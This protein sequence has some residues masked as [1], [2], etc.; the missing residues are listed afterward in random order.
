M[1]SLNK[2]QAL[3]PKCCEADAIDLSK[4]TENEKELLS[5]FLQD[6]QSVIV[7]AHHVKHSLEWSWFP[8]EASRE[9]S[10][11]PA[12]LHLQAEAQKVMY[13]LDKMGYQSTLIPYPGK[14]GIRFKN[15]A[16]KTGL[17]KIGDNFLFLHNEWGPWTH[18]RVIL[19]NA[20][21][22]D[23]LKSCEEVCIHC[24]AC[25]TAC[26]AN[27]IKEKEL[28]GTTCGAYQH[29]VAQTIPAYEY[30]CEVCLRICPIGASP[31]SVSIT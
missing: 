19:T 28:L 27:A 26:P 12:D 8:F 13:Y 18:L 29:S 2:I 10:V 30:N 22:S 23:C 16:D 6:F 31:K 1:I 9:G 24:G 25:R 5:E 14:C 3:L 7:I 21:I 4:L 20:E 15:L 17:G 11:H